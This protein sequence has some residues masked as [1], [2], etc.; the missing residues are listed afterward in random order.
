MAG[1]AISSYT[2]QG[3]ELA[4]KIAAKFPGEYETWFYFASQKQY[5]DFLK[6]KFD[7]V[8][9]PPHL[10]GHSSSPFIW[11]ER[12]NSFDIELIGG[13]TNLQK[14]VLANP[15]LSADPELK[16]LATQSWKMGHI[17]HNGK[18]ALPPTVNAA[19]SQ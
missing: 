6:V 7:P 8:P 15:T 10:K 1:F 2:G 3:R 14:W 9:F 16:T 13:T 11:I 12:G 5:Y 4:A 17:F 19:P 18:G